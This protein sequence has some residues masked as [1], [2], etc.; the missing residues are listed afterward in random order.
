M[1]GRRGVTRKN[2][3]A[4]G[5]GEV[6][7]IARLEAALKEGANGIT[8]SGRAIGAY[9]RDNIAL[10]P[11]ETGASIAAKTGVSEMSVIRFV[12]GLGYKSLKEFKDDLRGDYPD[13]N[14]SVEDA[15]ERFRIR[16]DGFGE[17]RASLELEIRAVIKA[18]ELA[19]SERWQSIID[20]LAKRRHIHVVGFQA[21][22]GVALDFANR[23][24]Y[25]RAGVRFAEGLAG[26]YS[27]VLEVDPKESCLVLIDTAAYARKGILLARR[28]RE[29]GLP[30]VI[31]TDRF[32]NWAYAYT[33]LVLQGHTYVRTFWDSTASLNI[34][35]NLLI[36]AVAVRLGR[37]AED[38]FK[39]MRDLGDY[40][41]EFEPLRAQERERRGLASPPA[42]EP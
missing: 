23:M 24:K 19:A 2:G 9:L 16:H 41:Q 39:V 25:A 12:R 36:N 40:F 32:S 21:S 18:Y 11:F 5:R 20:L 10:L 28:A 22:K 33:D 42:E 34:I 6:P 26:V 8:P 29:I 3:P 38:R 7:A 30:I 14:Q 31:V 37:K 27:E 13:T 1:P 35:L 17:L 15:L 4:G